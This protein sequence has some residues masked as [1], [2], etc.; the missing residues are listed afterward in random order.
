MIYLKKSLITLTA[1][2]S[3]ILFSGIS[4]CEHKSPTAVTE[5]ECVPGNVEFEILLAPNRLYNTEG[6]RRNVVIQSQSEYED[7]LNTYNSAEY[8]GVTPAPMPID[9]NKR[10][11]AGVI[12]GLCPDSCYSTEIRS[13][14]TNCVEVTVKIHE[15]YR[16]FNS[17]CYLAVTWPQIFALINKT[18][19]Q[20]NFVYVDTDGDG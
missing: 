20:I 18:D 12:M 10:T 11:L 6:P 17:G 2:V 8:I 4:G 1:V 9:F 15:R 19:L 14:E 13:I 5:L 16:C 7:F 3:F